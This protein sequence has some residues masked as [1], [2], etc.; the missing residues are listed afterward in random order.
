MFSGVQVTS[1]LPTHQVADEEVLPFFW[2]DAYE[3]PY[4][5]AGVVFLFGKVWEPEANTH[6]RY[7]AI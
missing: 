3:D 7:I 1:G 4:H 2:L 6:V 5:Q